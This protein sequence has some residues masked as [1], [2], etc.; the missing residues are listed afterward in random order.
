MAHEMTPV[1]AAIILSGVLLAVSMFV[2]SAIDKEG[3]ATCIRVRAIQSFFSGLGE[4]FW[5]VW[6]VLCLVVFA[7]GLVLKATHHDF[8]WK[9]HASASSPQHKAQPYRPPFRSRISG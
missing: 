6:L 4:I 3:C 8:K 9:S 7:G 5:T 1:D 2:L